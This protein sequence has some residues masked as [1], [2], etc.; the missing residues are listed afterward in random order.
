MNFDGN[1]ESEGGEVTDRQELLHFLMFPHVKQTPPTWCCRQPK[2]NMLLITMCANCVRSI[3]DFVGGAVKNILGGGE[4]DEKDEKKGGFFSMFGGGQKDEDEDKGGLFSFGD[5][6]KKKKDEDKGGF[7]SKIFDSDDDREKKSGFK[8][9]FS[10]QEQGASAGGEGEAE[11]TGG[12]KDVGV[13]DGGT[14]CLLMFILIQSSIVCIMT[15]IN[16]MFS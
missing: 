5:D 9:L 15:K 16:A 4:K 8:G 1:N 3:G 11:T 12:N 13:S 7:F 10:E 2:S 6:E 14:E